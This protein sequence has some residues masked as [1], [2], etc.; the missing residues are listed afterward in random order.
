MAGS[1]RRLRLLVAAA[2]VLIGASIVASA[3]AAP[4]PAHR[5]VVAL[6]S[7]ERRVLASINAFRAAHHLAPLH[8]STQLTLAARAHSREMA[9]DGFFAH[10]SAGGA[11]FWQRIR[12][13]YG[14]G[15]RRLWAVGENLLWSSRTLSAPGA[16]RAWEGSPEHLAN[17]LDP[18]WREIGVSAVRATAAPGAFQGRDVTIVT[19]DFGVRR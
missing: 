19:T 11:P 5:R 9:V 6:S 18:R 15:S 17:L 1:L 4:S 3:F 2:L 14:A 7:L 13:F 16:L 12:R 8:I 10:E